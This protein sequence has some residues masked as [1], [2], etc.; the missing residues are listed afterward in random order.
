MLTWFYAQYLT[1]IP[2]GGGNNKVLK[3][4]KQRL[5]FGM[6]LYGFFYSIIHIYFQLTIIF[7]V[8]FFVLIIFAGYLMNKNTVVHTG[9]SFVHFFTTYF[10]KLYLPS[11]HEPKVSRETKDLFFLS[12]LY[13]A[14][15]ASAFIFWMID[16]H[17][18]VLLYN[19]P[20][21]LPN[22][23]LHA[24]WHFL[25]AFNTHCG[26]QLAIGLRAMERN[27]GT[28]ILPKTVWYG[29]A[30]PYFGWFAQT[31]C[32]NM[33]PLKGGEEEKGKKR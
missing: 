5:V 28:D 33:R 24:W 18:C 6:I 20:F 30:T 22:P 12:V 26:L 14:A 10:R 21:G 27:R 19:L 29:G 9:R 3:T 13:V 4:K 7:Q 2:K 11:N 31:N 16:Q 17:G 32:E 23:Q 8:Q 25:T 1:P 15:I